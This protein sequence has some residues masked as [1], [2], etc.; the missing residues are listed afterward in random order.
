MLAM[1]I[2]FSATKVRSTTETFGVGI[3]VNRGHDAGGDAEGV[4]KHLDDG[5][6]AVGSAG[7]V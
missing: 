2:G 7:G 4:V 6:Q 1:V 3:A 5:R